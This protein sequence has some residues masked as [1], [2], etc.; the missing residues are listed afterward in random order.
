[1]Y[2]YLNITLS[3]VKLLLITDP[4]TTILFQSIVTDIFIMILFH[5]SQSC[6]W[7]GAGRQQK[8]WRYRLSI[9]EVQVHILVLCPLSS[10]S[11]WSVTLYVRFFKLGRLFLCRFQL[12]KCERLVWNL[13]HIYPMKIKCCK[14]ALLFLG[15]EFSTH[16]RTSLTWSLW[17]NPN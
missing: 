12:H 9:H 3:A 10:V 5:G 6:R 13:L 11:A 16:L 1:M 8:L 14:K 7:Q 15:L 4:G 17:T 2:L